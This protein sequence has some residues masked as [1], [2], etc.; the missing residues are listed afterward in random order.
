LAILRIGYDGEYDWIEGPVMA[1]AHRFHQ[2][3]PIYPVSDLEYAPLLYPPLY[4]WV[5]GWAMKIFGA[6]YSTGRLVSILATLGTFGFL[7]ALVTRETKS[8]KTGWVAVGLYAAVYPFSDYWYDLARVDSLFIFFIFVGL[9]F[10]KRDLRMKSWAIAALFFTFAVLTK[11]TAVL[12]LAGAGIWAFL[13][14]R[15]MGLFFGGLAGGMVA[16]TFFLLNSSTEGRFYYYLF[17]VPGSHETL[18]WKA[19]GL[20]TK[21]IFRPLSIGILLSV[22][23]IGKLWKKK[24]RSDSQFY[25]L[26]LCTT[27]LMGLMGRAKMGGHINNYLP[28]IASI[29]WMAGLGFYFLSEHRLLRPLMG[30]FF[31]L[32]LYA[33]NHSN[34]IRRD[35]MAI[36]ETKTLFTK[37][38]GSLF[39]PCDGYL[40]QLVGK[41]PSA[42]LGA[43]TDLFV[44]DLSAQKKNGLREKVAA[45]FE[46]KKF[47]AVILLDEDF[48]GRWLF[49]FKELEAHYRLKEKV[50]R[51]NVYLP[52]P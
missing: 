44:T 22:L 23:M 21:E 45:A 31:L 42:H 11:H 40:P 17:T 33:P 38:P 47:G 29:A 20:I 39:A 51:R 24:R 37:Y 49:P 3:L 26:I 30:F 36:E 9:Y 43:V 32:L 52:K 41:N 34:I 16:L 5:V 18:Y 35:A 46:A 25:F 4:P 2:G 50:G 48:Y 13:R 6:H 12:V 27:F 7:G 10:L 15:R 14:D 28:L 8:W 19:A 1:S